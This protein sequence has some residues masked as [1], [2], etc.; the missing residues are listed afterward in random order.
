MKESMKF[1]ILILVLLYFVSPDPVPGP[2]DDA[3]VLI[4]GL[5]VRNRLTD[6]S[7]EP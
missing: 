5:A 7:D 3:I 1:L 4:M 2:I 6:K